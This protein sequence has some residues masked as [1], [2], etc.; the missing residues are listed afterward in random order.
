[1]KAVTHHRPGEDEIDAL[2]RSGAPGLELPGLALHAPG[3]PLSEPS[4]TGRWPPGVIKP[5]ICGFES[6]ANHEALSQNL[7][8]KGTTATLVNVLTLRTW[9][10]L[11]SMG[12]Q[13]SLPSTE[14]VTDYRRQQPAHRL[15]GKHLLPAQ[16]GNHNYDEAYDDHPT[17]VFHA[18]LLHGTREDFARPYGLLLVFAPSW[19]GERPGPPPES[20]QPSCA[21]IIPLLQGSSDGSRRT[22]EGRAHRLGVRSRDRSCATVGRRAAWPGQRAAPPLRSLTHHSA[23]SVVPIGGPLASERPSRMDSIWKG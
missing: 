21:S 16:Q 19:V 20:S 5:G 23:L 6:D 11:N 7:E 22:R 3:G 9:R 14:E 12:E 13:L 15:G 18:L 17:A 10:S 8:R 1:V 4:L 2:R